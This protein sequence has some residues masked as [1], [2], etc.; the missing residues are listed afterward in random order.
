MTLH[1]CVV[2]IDGSG[3]SSVS[4]GAARAA[5]AGR[6]V[7]T[8]VAGDAFA[9]FRPLG[10]GVVHEVRS[11]M[12]ASAAIASWAKAQA[13]RLVDR[14]ALYPPFKLA[15]MAFQDS[16]AWRLGRRHACAA[17]VSD[18]NLLINA[19]GRGGNYRRP[20]SEGA[21]RGREAP[22]PDDVATLFRYLLDDV[23]LPSDAARRLP[24]LGAASLLLRALRRVGLRPAWL[25]DVV[26]FLD[27]DASLALERVRSRGAKV[28]AHEN[29]ADLTQARDAYR[30]ALD[31]FERYRGAGSVVVLDVGRMSRDE[32]IGAAT[33]AITRRLPSAASG[34]S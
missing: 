9:V 11:D 26:L 15:Q 7:V 6:G 14:R 1:A 8:G 16:A 31:A 29:I 24:R 34:R 20:A 21:D 5:C 18:G 32:A 10:D 22:T 19:A 33:E 28:D 25:P 12:P 27:L 13:K 3:K 23:P 2:G 17:V 30:R 4:A